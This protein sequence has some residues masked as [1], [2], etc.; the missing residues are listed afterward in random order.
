MKIAMNLDISDFVLP[1]VEWIAT[2]KV[3]LTVEKIKVH[4]P[5]Q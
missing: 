5:K 2:I 4:I 1:V 3:Q